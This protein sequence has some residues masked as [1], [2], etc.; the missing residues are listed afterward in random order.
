MKASIFGRLRH[1][2][3]NRQD[4]AA[5]SMPETSAGRYSWP[6][7]PADE[8]EAPGSSRG[9]LFAA[10]FVVAVSLLLVGGPVMA[11][12]LLGGES[13]PP[14]EAEVAQPGGQPP[15]LVVASP[16]MGAPTPRPT[17]ARATTVVITSTPSASPTSTSIAVPIE[18]QAPSDDL[19]LA[20]SEDVEPPLATLAATAT[21]ETPSS[22]GGTETAT[23]P[24][25][26]SS[27]CTLSI[28]AGPALLI[29]YGTGRSQEV[30]VSG[31]G[32]G[33]TLDFTAQSGASWIVVTPASGSLS[34][35]G[36][37]TLLVSVTDEVQDTASG[38]VQI[39]SAAGTVNVVVTLQPA[40]PTAT[41]V[42]TT[43]PTTG[44]P[45]VEPTAEPTTAPTPE[46]TVE[47][48]AEPTAAATEPTAATPTPAPSSGG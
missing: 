9:R 13:E 14:A 4:A 44:E 46:P 35:G 38:T 15:P 39:S 42:P 48:T 28:A 20:T 11:M 5:A 40:A 30:S 47:P 17:E 41:P 10:S 36:S 3:A 18:T 7:L 16:A 43:G 19:P 21:P 1:A 45:T 24:V 31:D 22:E 2:F 33:S 34:P 6:G 25:G 8:D 26:T 32:C 23:P 12:A 37:A 29:F 27:P